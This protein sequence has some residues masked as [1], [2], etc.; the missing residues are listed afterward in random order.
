M[1]LPIEYAN[2]TAEPV[3]QW[4]S[5]LLDACKSPS[6]MVIVSRQHEKHC[7]YCKAIEERRAA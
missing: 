1:P 7:R 3:C 5:M 2:V 4:L 6:E